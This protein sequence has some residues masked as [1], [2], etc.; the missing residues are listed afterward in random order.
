MEKILPQLSKA[1]RSAIDD[2]E[3]QRKFIPHV[4][5]DLIG[6]ETCPVC[7]TEIAYDWC[8][9]IYENRLGLE[10]WEGLLVTSLEIGF[11]HLDPRDCHTKFALIHTL[12]GCRYVV[13]QT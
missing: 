10:D 11:G 4:L 12:R 7:L 13:G 6:L 9:V 5:R 3:A 8:P 2:T 1:I